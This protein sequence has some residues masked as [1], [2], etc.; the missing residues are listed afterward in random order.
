MCLSTQVCCLRKLTCS[1][2]LVRPSVS[3]LVCQDYT[4][5]HAPSSKCIRNIVFRSWIMFTTSKISPRVSTYPILLCKGNLQISLLGHHV[6]K[7]KNCLFVSRKKVVLARVWTFKKN[8]EVQ[9]HPTTKTHD[10]RFQNVSSVITRLID[11]KMKKKYFSRWCS[12]L[13]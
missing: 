13:S 9:T 1:W 2:Q 4:H 6:S 3:Q 8:A 12:F 10:I 7:N 11:E 5:T